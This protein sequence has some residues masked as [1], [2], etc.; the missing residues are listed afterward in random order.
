MARTVILGG[1]L[2]ALAAV[3]AP[4]MA[5]DSVYTELDL[6]R[7]RIVEEVEEGESVSWECP[8]H[9]TLPLLVGSGDGR[10][11]IDAG[12]ENEEWETIPPFNRPGPR[13]EWRMDG[14]VAVAI[15]FRL[16][17][18]DPEHPDSALFVETIGR[19]DAPGCTVAVID[20]RLPNANERARQ[21]ADRR[22]S[23]FRCGTDVAERHGR[24]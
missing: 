12:I 24:G 18:V 16:V 10:F 5:N 2:A 23:G 8:G 1:A 3:A 15:I 17:S 11:D 14:R 4:A 6:D 21:I 19:A 7:C 22:A 9:A 20:A 13:V